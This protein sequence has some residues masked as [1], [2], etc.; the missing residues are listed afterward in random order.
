MSLLVT[1]IGLVMTYEAVGVVVVGILTL[2]L[3]WVI[4]DIF[5]G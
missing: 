5:V 3:C 4:G 2:G 1:F